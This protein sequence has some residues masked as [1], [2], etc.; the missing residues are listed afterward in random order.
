MDTDSN[1][2]NNERLTT[3]DVPFFCDFE[4]YDGNTVQECLQQNCN[5]TNDLK[6]KLRQW[7][8]THSITVNA[9]NAWLRIFNLNLPVLP[10]DYRTLMGTLRRTVCNENIDSSP[11]AT[12]LFC[13]TGIL[14]PLEIFLANFIKECKHFKLNGI[15]FDGNVYSFDMLRLKN[16]LHEED[17][18]NEYLDL[19][20]TE[21]NTIVCSETH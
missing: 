8:S 9:D 7:M 15:Q 13:G 17:F 10:N 21:K 1:N 19:D 4:L 16:Q 12:A 2:L 5:G 6:E 11:F 20:C 14:E 18:R 3:N